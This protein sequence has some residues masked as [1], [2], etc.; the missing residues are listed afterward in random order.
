[1]DFHVPRSL[2]VPTAGFDAFWR[3]TA[4]RQR[5]YHRRLLGHRGV[6]TDDPVIANYRFTNPY[7]AA[8]RVSQFLIS[9]VIY[10][11]DRPWEDVFARVLLFKIF[12][13]T[14]T[15][16]HLRAELGEPTAEHLYGER[17]QAV[18]DARSRRQPIYSPAYI[19]PPPMGTGPK[20]HRH[21][22]LIRNLLD[23]GAHQRIE[24]APQMEDA[25]RILLAYP[26]IGPFL[27]YQ[28]VTD[29]NYAPQLS[30]GEDQFTMPGP[31][32]LRG[33]KKCFSDPRDTSPADLIRWTMESQ[34]DAFRV[35]DLEWPNL[36]GRPL[37]L[38]DVQNLYCEVDKYCRVAHPELSKGL[39]GKRIKQR[40]VNSG[41][42]ATAWFP[43][44]WGIN[45]QVPRRVQPESAHVAKPASIGQPKA[46]SMG[47][48][49]LY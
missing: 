6:L 42:R 32:A 3:F 8:D 18:L 22:Q 2:P 14:D 12:N 26:S 9:E 41:R 15:W 25:Y 40:F 34:A 33:L 44:K 36:W 28:Y 27:A 11:S 7:R 10:G 20:H 16:I 47:Q 17:I 19:M 38:I 45:P 46:T 48:L 31:G 1:M 24:N 29:L 43:P 30:W 5:V 13:R 4:E 49:L 37:Q 23:S 39:T 21:L 35:R